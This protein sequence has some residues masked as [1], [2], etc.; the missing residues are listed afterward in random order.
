[1]LSD[2]GVPDDP[3]QPPRRRDVNADHF[4]QFSITMAAGFARF[5][6]SHGNAQVHLWLLATHPDFRRRG[7]AT[8]LCQWGLDQA[9]LRGPV[10]TTVLASQMG[11]ALYTELGFS[12][13]G[14]FIV[15]V[16]DEPEELCI[17]ALTHAEEDAPGR[18]SSEVQGVSSSVS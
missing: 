16:D 7:A 1:M 5:F 9:A 2:L 4:R 11:K 15:R 14:S 8:R 3:Q 6:G 18:T 13:D 12:L 17:W 10:C